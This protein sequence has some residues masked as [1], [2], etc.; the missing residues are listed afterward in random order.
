MK[1]TEARY[2]TVINRLGGS[3]DAAQGP[4]EAPK[5]AFDQLRV[6]ALKD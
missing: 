1:N 4:Q 2:L 6:A 3:P 5:P